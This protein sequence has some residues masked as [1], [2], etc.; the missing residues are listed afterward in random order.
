VRREPKLTGPPANQPAVVELLTQGEVA[1]VTLSGVIDERFPGFG[2]LGA[3]ATVVLNVSEVTRMNSFGVRQWLAAIAALPGSMMRLYLLGCPTF[4]VDHLN[5]MASFGGA[6]K[7][8]TVLAPYMCPDCGTGAN[9]I[10]DVLVEGATLL[11]DPPDRECARCGTRLELDEAPETYFAFVSRYAAYNLDVATAQLLASQGLYTPPDAADKPP[12]IGKTVLRGVTYFRIA[13]TVGKLFHARPF[14][15]ARGEIVIDLGEVDRFDPS[16]QREWRRLITALAPHATALTF[17]D[18]P[19]TF[20]TVVGDT[21][22]ASRSVAVASLRVP[23]QCLVCGRMAQL[24]HEL[25]S[26][27]WPPRFDDGH[28]ETC[29]GPTRSRLPADALAALQKASTR[30]P[31]AVVEAIAHRDDAAVAPV[32]TLAVDDTIL[33]KYEIIG[34]V[35]ALGAGD[36]FLAKHLGFDSDKPVAIKRINGQNVDRRTIERFLDDARGASRLV[37]PNIARVLEVGESSGAL[38]LAIE[39]VHGKDLWTVFTTLSARRAMLPLADTCYIA[40]EIAKALEYAYASSD[41]AGMQM[42]IVHGALA[43][44]DVML[45]ID[46]A[47]KVLDLGV[48]ST[49]ITGHRRDAPGRQAYL[50]PE[51]ALYAHAD[52]RSD[53]F[54]LGAMMFTFLSGTVPSTIHDFAQLPNWAPHVPPALAALV[55]RLVDAAPDNRPQHARDVVAQLT[56][57]MEQYSLASSPQQ[58]ASLLAVTFPSGHAPMVTDGSGIRIDAPHEPRTRRPRVSS[59]QIP[60]TRSPSITKS[61]PLAVRQEFVHEQEKRRNRENLINLSIGVTILIV[62]MVSAYLIMSRY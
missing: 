30:P 49:A 29:N 39:Y 32:E 19:I 10:I 57:V 50:A 58:L 11:R 12:R 42:V 23:Y 56:E 38:A 31:P 21:L 20:L 14:L 53:L 6:G 8:L 1:V 55:V 41:A 26:L 16:A 60:L 22:T 47:V 25:S 36:V 3:V 28:C 45:S 54:S 40:R 35:S 44:H 5:M 59:I 52:H 33:G 9:E 24:R 61:P 43:P 2:D 15:D 17:I 4:F 46:G 34:R 62:V 37:H 48:A 13:G 18:V 27:D 51:I 7:V